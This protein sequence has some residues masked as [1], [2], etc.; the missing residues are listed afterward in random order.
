M[1]LPAGT[2]FIKV[3]GYSSST[4]GAYVLHL[5]RIIQAQIMPAQVTAAQVK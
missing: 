4:A 2:Y 5:D 3:A 1:A